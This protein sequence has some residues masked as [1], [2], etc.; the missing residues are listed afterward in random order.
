MDL[1][2]GDALGVTGTEIT[3][4]ARVNP[5][6]WRDQAFQGSVLNKEQNGAG[7]DRG[8]AVRVGANGTVNFLLGNGSWQE[9]STP[10]G[11][12][13]LD[14]WQHVA[15]T[16][17]GATMRIYVDG[18]EA[19]ARAVSH[20]VADATAAL[21]VGSSESNPA[22]T[23][24]G[25]IDEVRVWSVARSAEQIQEAM[26]TVDPAAEGLVG[27]WRFDEGSGQIAADE[28]GNGNTGTLGAS[29]AVGGDDPAWTLLN[30]V[31]AEDDAG[32]RPTRYA[33]DQSYPNPFRGATT[34]RFAL[35]EAGPVRLHLFDVLGRRVAVL[36]DEV[37]SAGTHAV[38]L[39]ASALPSGVYV[40]RLEA[41]P[42]T[43]TRRL[44]LTR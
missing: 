42:Y 26:D 27:Y 33:L 19:A 10:S 25:G 31:S 9:V 11:A 21:W 8:Y 35:P 17:D 20:T 43:A 39:N 13:V 18:E 34:I 14:A 3:L 12:L 38:R 4:E 16:F 7:N 15:A 28:T 32:S 2:D 29:T 36:A 37:M 1:G 40:V 41:G 24:P 30:P 23:F 5:S 22:R 44:V 6:A